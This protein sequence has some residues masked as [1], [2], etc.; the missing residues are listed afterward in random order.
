MAKNSLLNMLTG[1]FGKSISPTAPHTL[2]IGND[3]ERNLR[4]AE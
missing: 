1:V 3:I 2:Y 4:E